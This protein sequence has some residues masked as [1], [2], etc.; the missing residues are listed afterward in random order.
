[1]TVWCP[2]LQYFTTG[3]CNLQDIYLFA[4]DALLATH[5]EQNLKM[6]W[7]QHGIRKKRRTTTYSSLPLCAIDRESVL[8]SNDWSK[9]D[10]GSEIRQEK[11]MRRRRRRESEER[12][13]NAEAELDWKAVFTERWD[14]LSF[15][16]LILFSV[17]AW[18]GE[19]HRK[20]CLMLLCS[21]RPERVVWRCSDRQIC[22]SRSLEVDKQ[23]FSNE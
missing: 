11:S 23:G 13:I 22:I 2:K 1:M 19:C 18:P 4:R 6:M 15:F 9:S 16:F 3:R 8:D 12:K 14:L 5:F 7:D 21:D 20:R 17:T 10:S